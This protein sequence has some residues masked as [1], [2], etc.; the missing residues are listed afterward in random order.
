MSL[1]RVTILV[2][3][4][5]ANCPGIAQTDDAGIASR[6]AVIIGINEYQKIRPLEFCV[7]D[8]KLLREVLMRNGF[9]ADRILL[10]TDDADEAHLRPTLSNVYDALG[11]WA[12]GPRPEDT[13]LFFFSGHGLRDRQG[14]DY[15]MPVDAS[16]TSPEQTAIPVPEVLRLLQQGRS[17]H[18]VVV[19]DAC[20]DL[21]RGTRAGGG[22]GFGPPEEHTAPVSESTELVMLYSCRGDEQSHE[23]PEKGHGVFSYFLVRGIS[24]EAASAEGT[25]TVNGLSSYLFERVTQW[26]RDRSLLQTPQSVVEWSGLRPGGDMELAR[27]G[28]CAALAGRVFEARSN[29]P[30]AGAV[31]RVGDAR[32]SSDEQGRYQ[33][34]DL[35]AGTFEVSLEAPAPYEQSRSAMVTAAPGRT[36]DL[37][38]PLQRTDMGAISVNVWPWATVWLD[39]QEAGETPLVIPNVAPG[40]H[41]IIW[42]VQGRERRSETKQ[43]TVVAGSVLRLG[44]QPPAPAP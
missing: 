44:T 34:T 31:V 38:W 40:E 29:D 23:W 42:K 21:G 12:Q 35:P 3:L 26:A 37:D 43:V 36:V 24:G 30:V 9:D 14:T 5:V 28:G 7:P 8:A 33:L 20:R 41:T 19:L 25:V 16:P 32:V 2:L 39:D 22:S 17:Q 15:L 6:W 11:S 10:M 13:V 4:F 27:T 1:A 18:I